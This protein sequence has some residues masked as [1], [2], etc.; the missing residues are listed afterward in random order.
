M[1]YTP[2][3]LSSLV[4][5]TSAVA[6]IN[7]NFTALQTAI[8]KTLSRDGTSPNTMSADLDMNNCRIINLA[9]A[10]TESEFVNREYV[11]NLFAGL[12]IGRAHV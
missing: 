6:N 2:V 4:N 3:L 5:E 11:D 10:G 9:V 8:E 1:K 12:E 7:A